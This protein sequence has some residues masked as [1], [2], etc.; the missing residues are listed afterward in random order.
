MRS[1]VE[2]E[3]LPQLGDWSSVEELHE[4]QRARLPEVLARAARSPFYRSRFGPGPAPSSAEDFFDL[5]LTEKGDLRE[6]YPFGMLAVDR[7]E[8]ATYHESSGSSGRPTAS[9]YT[10]TDWVDLAQRYARKWI[11]I[12]AEDTF[13][14]RTPY[15]MMISGH[16]A[17]AAA[18]SRGATVV[19]GDCRSSAMPMS[20]VVRVLHDLGVSLTWGNPTETL[21]WAAA[22]RAAGYDPAVDFPALRALFVAAEPLTAIRRERISRI[23]GGVPVIEEYGAT[24]AGTLA[25]MSPDGRLRLWADRVLFEVLDPV[26]GTLKPEGRGQ[27]VVTPLY[28]EAMPLLRYNLADDV[29]VSYDDTDDGWHLPSVRVLGRSAFQYPVGSRSVTQ[30]QVETLIFGLPLEDQVMFWR[31][32]AE[33]DRLHLEFEVPDERREHAVGAL[34]DAARRDL[35]VPCTLSPC[36]PGSLVPH[37]A[38]TGEVDVVKPRSLFGPGEDWNKAILYF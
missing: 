33:P 23:W 13:L 17:H 4:L 28:R 38:L 16:L 19:P 35:G 6:Q 10:E 34:A 5:E 12:S 11:G 2:T 37:A 25:G 8:L 36:R 21:M 3:R 7:R 32:R 1:A 22:A 20:R 30:E 24:E 29:E 15:A 9:Y 18:R 26:T 27:L 14:V 31:G